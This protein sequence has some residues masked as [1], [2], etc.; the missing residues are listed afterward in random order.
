MSSAAPSSSF[1]SSSSSSSSSSLSSNVNNQ[2]FS[3]R[4]TDTEEDE[5]NMN[6]IGGVFSAPLLSL[7]DS[8]LFDATGPNSNIYTRLSLAN[9]V[10]KAMI[11]GKNTL[12]KHPDCPLTQDEIAAIHL[13]TQESS[14]YKELN[15]IL[16]ERNRNTSKHL[17]SYLRL[18]VSGLNKLP[19]EKVT[20]FRGVKKK[21]ICHHSL[22][23]RNDSNMVGMY[24]Y[25]STSTS[26]TK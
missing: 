13:Y 10:R 24:K 6:S 12:L 18:L 2:S 23:K 16:R 1:S 9:N 8:L 5:E 14:F 19:K 21:H 3:H 17:L 26:I 4:L 22:C 11:H 15:A 7:H 25:N 20:L